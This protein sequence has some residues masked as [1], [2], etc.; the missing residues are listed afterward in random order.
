MPRRDLSLREQANVRA[1]LRLLRVRFGNWRGVERA[2]PIS[3]SALHDIIAERVEV[4]TMIAF[5]IA[6]FLDV[7]LHHVLSGEALPPGTCKHCGR[8]NEE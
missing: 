1:Y 7:S 2:L 5:R 4:S 8:A 6:K 3:H